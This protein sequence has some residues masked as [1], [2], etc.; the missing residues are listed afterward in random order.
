MANEQKSMKLTDKE[1]KCIL[2]AL[3]IA[4]WNHRDA[5]NRFSK[6]CTRILVKWNKRWKLLD[7]IAD[8]SQGGIG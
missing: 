4:R 3:S 7:R 2:R 8:C 6:L 1:A 5:D